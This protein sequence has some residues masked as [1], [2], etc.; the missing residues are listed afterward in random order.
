MIAAAIVG[1]LPVPILDSAAVG[2]VTG[3]MI[4]RISVRDDPA[5]PLKN[6]GLATFLVLVAG[7]LTPLLSSAT[8][9]WVKS[10]PVVGTLAGTLNQPL[11]AALITYGIGRYWSNQLVAAN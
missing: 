1:G 9:G 7:F 2:I 4:W 3:S 5:R 10:I 8:A 6:R 11:V